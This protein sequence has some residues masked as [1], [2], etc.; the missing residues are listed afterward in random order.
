MN[1]FNKYQKAINELCVHHKVKSLYAFG[2]VLEK[3][4]KHAGD[5]D[6]IVTFNSAITLKNYADNYYSLKQALQ[7]LFKKPV[8]LLEEQAI[9]NPYFRDSISPKKQ[10]VYAA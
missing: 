4:I 6:L 2:S 8:D 1:N 3:D 10:L 5:V 9:K 7:Q